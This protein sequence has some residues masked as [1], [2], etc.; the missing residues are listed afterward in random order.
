MGRVERRRSRNRARLLTA[1]RELFA[2]RGMQST[3][4]AEIAEHA[5]IATGSF[6]SYFRTK[7]ELL[8]ALLEEEFASQL[9]LLELRQAQVNDPAEKVSVAHRHLVRVAQAD[10]DWAWLLVRLDAS[11]RIAWAV[12]G[13]AAQRDL[14]DGVES[15][16]FHVANERL[17]L[18]ASGGSLFAVMHSQLI[19]EAGEHADCEHAEG[20]LRSFGID[21]GQAAEIA[22]RP[23]PEPVHR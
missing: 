17:A 7:D 8:D 16:R 11:Q 23:L 22:R 3:A 19:G 5:D 14:Q 4:I 10:P 20:V 15:G 12:L 1:A 18:S 6:Y 13:Q 9:R 21:R 2:A